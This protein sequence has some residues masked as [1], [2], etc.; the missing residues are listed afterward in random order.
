MKKTHTKAFANLVASL[1]LLAFEIWAYVQTLGFK[2]VKN[3]AVQPASFPQ[4]MCIGMMVFTVIL[5][6]QSLIS[7]KK[8]DMDDP[9]MQEAASINIFK[10]KGV[11]AGLFVIV[12]CIAYAALFKVLGYVL[13][14]A[15]V[16]AIIMWLIGKRDVKQI[17]LVSILVPLLMWLVFYKL[18]T[19]NIPMGVLEPL[20]N[21]IDM[22]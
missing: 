21:L 2:V 12:L 16:A 1:I 8:M 20:K 5:L 14:S 15:I 4:I 19:V 11:Q 10:N 17:L 7:L 6:V 18:L 9:N 13:A 22:I 3:A